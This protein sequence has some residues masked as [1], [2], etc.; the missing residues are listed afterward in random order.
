MSCTQG[1][2]QNRFHPWP[3]TQNVPA[4]LAPLVLR[5]PLT[6]SII[7]PPSPLPLSSRITFDSAKF[8]T[9]FHATPPLFHVGRDAYKGGRRREFIEKFETLPL[10]R[11]LSLPLAHPPP[12]PSS[13]PL[14]A[15]HP[16]QG[17]IAGDPPISN[18]GRCI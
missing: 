11:P 2:R 9:S 15:S 10:R 16:V 7:P 5:Y 3:M 13:V 18:F 17:S 8:E 1:R 4:P 12:S 14:Y 6:P